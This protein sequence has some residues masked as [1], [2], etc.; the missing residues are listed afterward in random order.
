MLVRITPFLN[1]MYGIYMCIGLLLRNT[2][3]R[4][5]VLQKRVLCLILFRKT[6]KHATPLFLENQLPCIKMPFFF[7]GTFVLLNA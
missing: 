4:L 1:Y 7:F 5:L 6:R 3:E 2:L